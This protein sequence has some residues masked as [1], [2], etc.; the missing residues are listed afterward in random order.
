MK[1]RTKNASFNEPHKTKELNAEENE[2]ANFFLK[3]MKPK[4]V[5][6]LTH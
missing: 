6:E 1:N 5:K 2:R 3:K 4:N